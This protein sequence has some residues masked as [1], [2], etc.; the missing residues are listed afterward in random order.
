MGFITQQLTKYKSAGMNYAI[1]IF[2]VQDQAQRE[3][4]MSLFVPDVIPHL[5]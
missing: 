4:N 5:I 1:N 2:M 3:R